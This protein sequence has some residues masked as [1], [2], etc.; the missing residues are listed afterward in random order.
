M[1]LRLALHPLDLELTLTSGQAFRWI[2][3]EPGWE[4]VVRDRTVLLRQV[5]S[6]LLAD[7][8]G[9]PAEFADQL[10][11]YFRGQDD[12]ATIHRA[13]RADPVIR[14]ALPGLEG[15]RLLLQDPWE[16][17]ASFLLATYA[18]LP[19]ICGMVERLATE[20]GVLLDG[21]RHAFPTPGALAG[22]SPG[23]L[24]AL[25][26]GYRAPLLRELA[27]AWKPGVVRELHALPYEALHRRLQELPGIGPKVADCIAL[28]GF[29][30]LEA[31][32]IDVWIGR[33]MARHYRLRGSYRQVQRAARR[34]FGPLAG[35]AQQILYIRERQRGPAARRAPPASSRR[36]G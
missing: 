34:R 8:Q 35:Y 27:Q 24:R 6:G 18:N 4:G 30:R 15:L 10:T 17:A 23:E 7:S 29:G 21:G 19:R 12:L 33:A 20:F 5:Q 9:A 25:G 13:L 2:R 14:S 11:G 16:T 1:R 3:K 22:A 26:L 36:P 31:F 28:Y 32:P